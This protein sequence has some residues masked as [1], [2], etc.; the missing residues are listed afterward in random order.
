MVCTM[1]L[2]PLLM[3]FHNLRATGRNFILSFLRSPLLN[4]ESFVIASRKCNGN[5]NRVFDLLRN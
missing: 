4:E 1:R 5:F 3:I 2:V